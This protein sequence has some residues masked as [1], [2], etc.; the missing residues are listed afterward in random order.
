M[1]GIS[2]RRKKYK[3]AK[4]ILRLCN[5]RLWFFFH[6]R[7]ICLTFSLFFFFLFKKFSF[8]NV[9]SHFLSYSS[10]SSVKRNLK[11]E[12]KKINSNLGRWNENRNIFHF[13]YPLKLI[14]MSSLL[15]SSFTCATFIYFFSLSFRKII[16]FHTRMNYTT[17]IMCGEKRNNCFAAFFFP[18]TNCGGFFLS[19]SVMSHHFPVFSR[20]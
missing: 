4:I 11:S 16:W 18:E 12:W 15:Y 3:I 14:I 5:R 7:K 10:T 20:E 9:I 8:F 6:L 2:W 13:N 1:I 17:V 19:L